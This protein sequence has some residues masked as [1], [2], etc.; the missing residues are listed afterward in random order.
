ME[1]DFLL[2]AAPFGSLGDPLLAKALEQIT[3]VATA[4][5]KSVAPKLDFER[6][7]VPRKRIPELKMDWPVKPG[8]IQ[9][10]WELTFAFN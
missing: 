4:V 7:E 3:G 8:T 5:L 1:E 10:D 2:Y 6:M 9:S